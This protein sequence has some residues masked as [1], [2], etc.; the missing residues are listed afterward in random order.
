[1]S[2]EN[3]RKFSNFKQGTSNVNKK[4]ESSTPARAA[5]GVEN[6]GK[7]Y[8]GTLPKCDTYQRH[9]SGRYRL[10]K[11]ESCGRNGH[12][13]DT[14][15]VGTGAGRGG[16]RG[17]GNGN[18]NRQQGGNGRN[19]NRGNDG[20]GNGICQQAGNGNRNQNNTQA[21]NGGGNGRRPGYTVANISYAS[22]K[23]KSILGLVA[24]K[25]DNPHSKELANGKLVEANE[26]IE[27]DK[28]EPGEREFMLD[29]LPVELGSF[30]KVI[31]DTDF[32]T[33]FATPSGPAA[34]V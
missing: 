32:Y 25:L 2:G 10:R 19:G 29:L 27:N 9:H 1:M 22:L 4:G 13:K 7:G 34:I 30:D 15:W 5:T 16:N 12:T 20:N 3:K 31:M 33:A 11:C 28:I 8:V 24:S 18:G 14:C 23:F 26:V 6:K 21:G 17:H